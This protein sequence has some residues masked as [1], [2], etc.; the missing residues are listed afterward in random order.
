MKYLYK[1]ADVVLTNS[2]ESS[3]DLSR[4]IKL[5]VN[6][7]YNKIDFKKVFK[8]SKKK[9]MDKDIKF[10]KRKILI[11]IGRLEPQKDFMSLLKA[12]NDKRIISKYKLIIIGSGSLENKLLDYIKQ[13]K[14]EKDILLKG[15]IKNPYNYLSN[16]YFYLM[17]SL[18][19]GLQ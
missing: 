15:Y 9:I 8:L 1:Y 3:K 19:E 13:N 6:T 5:K 4:L 16:C 17:P 7:V 12:F 10:E 11:S 14:L 18:Y 2:F